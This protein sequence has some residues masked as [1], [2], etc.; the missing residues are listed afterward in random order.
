M[1]PDF[2]NLFAS[3]EMLQRPWFALAGD[4]AELGCHIGS[5]PLRSQGMRCQKEPVGTVVLAI[6]DKHHGQW[7]ATAGDSLTPHCSH[8]WKKHLRGE[9]QVSGS[10]QTAGAPAN[11]WLRPIPMKQGVI[12]LLRWLLLA[13]LHS[14]IKSTAETKHHLPQAAQATE[15][16]ECSPWFVL[17]ASHLFMFC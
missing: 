16:T 15:N 17:C 3:A 14:C 9:E 2:C 13:S 1:F 8:P 11:L 10:K 4:P 7:A 12:P 5:H 6:C